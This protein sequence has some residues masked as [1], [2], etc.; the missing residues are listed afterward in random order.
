MK[1]TTHTHTHTVSQFKLWALQ[2]T[3]RK[4]LAKNS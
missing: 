3:Y 1:A 4:G 2:V